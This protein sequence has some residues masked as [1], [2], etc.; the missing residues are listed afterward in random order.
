MRDC[1]L[2]KKC[3]QK[4]LYLEINGSSLITS[5]KQQQLNIREGQA[6]STEQT[7][8]KTPSCLRLFAQA[9]KG[10]HHEWIDLLK[11]LSFLSARLDDQDQAVRGAGFWSALSYVTISPQEIL[12]LDS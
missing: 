10:E 4:Y 8:R 3:T 12:C 7:G 6:N 5:R 2:I 1:H 9:L 11:F